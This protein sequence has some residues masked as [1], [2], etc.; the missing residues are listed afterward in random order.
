MQGKYSP[1][2]S[3][4]YSKDQDWWKKNGGG[5]GNGTEA[6]RIA[7]DILNEFDISVK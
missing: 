2:V 5:F 4:W 1:T 3:G 7:S 6:K